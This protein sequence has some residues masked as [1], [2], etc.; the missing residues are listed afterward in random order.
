[1]A[2]GLVYYY[3]W[4]KAPRGHHAAGDSSSQDED[5]KSQLGKADPPFEKW[6][7]DFE[8]A[9]KRAAQEN[10]DLLILFNASDANPV[11]QDMAEKIFAKPAFKEGVESQLVLVYVDF[12]QKPSNL[13]KVADPEQNMKLNRVYQVLGNFPTLILTDPEGRPFSQGGYSQEG[14]AAFAARLVK[15]REFH[16]RRDSLFKEVAQAEGPA[17]PKAAAEALGF[18][19]ERGLAFYYKKQVQEWGGEVRQEDPNNDR[20]FAEVFFEA[21]WYYEIPPLDQTPPPEISRL[22]RRLDDW[23]KDHAF[24]DKNRAARLHFSAGRLA[25]QAGERD[26]ALKYALDGLAYRPDNSHIHQDLFRLAG[27][28][29]LSCGSGFVVAPSG[30]LLTNAH[31]VASGGK[32]FIRVGT[33]L[34]SVPAKVI[35]QDT[36]RD[37]ALIQVDGPAG[38]T[39]TAL[40]VDGKRSLERGEDVA[41]LGY[42]LGEMFGSGLKLTTGRV[43]ATP[44]SGTNNMLLLENKINPGNSGGPLCDAHGNIVG[45]ISAKTATRAGTDSYGLALT[46]QDL[47]NFLA[48]HLKNYKPASPET[49]HLTWPEV[50]R[51]IS[52]SV[53]MIFRMP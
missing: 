49:K 23:K 44:E 30:Y 33:D 9:K 45:M 2:C 17:K 18:L 51:K 8:A 20:G 52:P 22:A 27:E 41:A 7:Q 46:G 10:K 40:P 39:L 21:D 13:S 50:N 53:F 16:E 34:K 6:T 32:I 42:P 25:A 43:S 1:V 35:A 11:C 47:D 15:H 38:L 5:S 26:A 37:I 28:L 36:E 31:V 14:P 3:A 29:G 24:K 19:A 48:K 12:P 4:L